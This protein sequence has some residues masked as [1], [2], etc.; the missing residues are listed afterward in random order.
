[1][2]VGE[3]VGPVRTAFTLLELVMI[4]AIVATLA[5]IAAPRYAAALT[6]YRVDGASKRIVAD[7]ELARATAQ[8]QSATVTVYFDVLND[9]YDIPGVPS[10]HDPDTDAGVDLSREPYRADL[11]TASFGGNN[12]VSFDGYGFPD[13][14]G[15]IAVSCGTTMKTINLDL[16][17]GLASAQ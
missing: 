8:T 5:A 4:L 9:R 17:T 15:V 2:N 13:S 7:L 14:G 6:S 10:L 3:T 12:K 1:M 16:E 11:V